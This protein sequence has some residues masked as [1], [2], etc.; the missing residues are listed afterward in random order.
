MKTPKFTDLLVN[1]KPFEYNLAPFRPKRFTNTQLDTD[2]NQNL[3]L[4][5]DR[6]KVSSSKRIRYDRSAYAPVDLIQWEDTLD[7]FLETQSK[8]IPNNSPFQNDLPLHLLFE[9]VFSEQWENRIDKGPGPLVLFYQDPNLIFSHDE[10]KKK[11]RSRYNL[12]N[13]KYYNPKKI[14]RDENLDVF[15]VQH[16][17]PA[18]TLHPLFYKTHLTKD[19]LRMY[20]RI[21]VDISNLFIK[22]MSVKKEMNA[23][24]KKPEDLAIND[25]CE[26]CLVEFSEEFPIFTN[27]EGM[28]SLINAYKREKRNEDKEDREKSS[29]N[30]IN[31]SL[32][33]PSPFPI[34][35]VRPGH[36][37]VAMSNNLFKA[38][39][40]KQNVNLFIVSYNSESMVEDSFPKDIR[41]TKDCKLPNENNIKKSIKDYK[42]VNDRF[43][44]D[45]FDDQNFIFNKNITSVNAIIRPVKHLLTAGQ[46]FPLMEVFSPH[47]KSLNTFCKN[48]L[49]MA[50][51][52]MAHSTIR[53]KDIDEMFPTF[54]EGSKRKWLKEYAERKKD[55][56]YILNHRS[57][58]R[59]VTPESVCQYESMLLSERLYKDGV[60]D[61]EGCYWNTSRNFLKGTI[62]VYKGD[63]CKTD[64]VAKDNNNNVDNYT[65][66]VKSNVK[67]DI[68]N[69][70]NSNN[71]IKDDEAFSYRKGTNENLQEIAL[72]R[73]L[74][75]EQALKNEYNLEELN[76]KQFKEYLKSLCKDK[77]NFDLHK[78]E[79]STKTRDLNTN[80]HNDDY[81][82]ENTDDNLNNK[83]F[84]NGKSNITDFVKN[85]GNKN[86][87]DINATIN[88]DNKIVGFEKGIKIIRVVNGR[89]EE[90][91]ITNE[92]TIN[93]YLKQRKKIKKDDKKNQLK[94][95]RCGEIG[96]MKTNKTCQFYIE[97]GKMSKKKKEAMKRRMKNIITE[98]VIHVINSLFLI[99]Y[100]S[101]FH[102]PVNT[103]KFV[104][105]LQFVKEPIDLCT[106]KNKARQHKY[107]R[108]ADFIRDLELMKENC[109]KYNGAEDSFGKIAEEMVEIG[110]QR[111]EEKKEELEDAEKMII[112]EELRDY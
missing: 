92:D 4:T 74:V 97:G 73:F 100:S 65:Q 41:F 68:N 7:T 86:T 78:N 12:S 90:E 71:N 44:S 36:T 50:A 21:T 81:N 37:V 82:N 101:V 96:H 105:Y 28:V 112:S 31:L 19:E 70:T 34:A 46:V 40:Y 107:L 25:E 66:D 11:K 98:N 103:K 43:E 52:S 93:E 47:S 63:A 108:Y 61:A 54:S 1:P 56:T 45:N 77:D 79:V 58:D 24:I 5:A 48:R 109:V 55:N 72:R 53:M 18:L 13:D 30:T 42:F 15:G 60:I 10:K 35:D 80:G 99:P 9:D 69:Y 95:G 104:N 16:S 23:F 84:D 64:N 3:H 88:Y 94:C 27:K 20:H 8:G 106:M 51:N 29:F 83:L 26:F 87:Y 85:E 17:V 89:R 111:A 49:K 102:K 22:F 39:L 2:E 75:Q 14:R 33:D 59:L 110:K 32:G 67:D 38:P 57:E 76:D 62:E 91:I 6:P